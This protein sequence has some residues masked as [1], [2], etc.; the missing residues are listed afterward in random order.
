M[1]KAKM[2]LFSVE[3]SGALG[4]LEYKRGIYGN[5]V[6][7]RSISSNRASQAQ[8]ANRAQFGRAQHYWTALTD[9]DVARWH[10]LFPD[11]IDLKADVVACYMRYP[12]H[13]VTPMAPDP[14]VEEDAPFSSVIVFWTSPGYAEIELQPAQAARTNLLVNGYVHP[15]P[16]PMAYIHPRQM[17]YDAHSD[18]GGAPM[19]LCTHIRADSARVRL[20]RVTSPQ[21]ILR[22]SWTFDVSHPP[23]A[24]TIVYPN[25][26]P[27]EV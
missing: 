16:Y 11:S 6:S 18:G 25:T 4:G 1:A 3:A 10:A 8:L 23:D 21:G 2:P 7:R 15:I 24:Y 27:P 22:G 13:D 12:L 17:R 20:D 5:V 19:Y 9:I 26:R 14:L